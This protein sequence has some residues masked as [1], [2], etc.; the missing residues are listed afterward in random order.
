MKIRPVVKS[1]LENIKSVIDSSGLFPS[2]MLD[3]MIAGYFSET[4]ECIWLTGNLEKESFVSYCAPE[5]MTEGTWN[6]YLIAVHSSL[7]GQNIGSKVLA[8][9]EHLLVSKR[10]R[11]L[12]VETSGLPEFEKTRTFYIKNKYTKEASIREFYSKGE[13]KVV[14][15]KKLS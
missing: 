14:F 6:L 12:I 2:E 8:H 15:W 1:D 10:V 13:D 5:K 11:I 7:Q 3:D 9:L 4:E